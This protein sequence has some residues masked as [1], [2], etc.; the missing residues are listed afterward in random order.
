MSFAIEILSVHLSEIDLNNVCLD[1]KLG[2]L[3][4]YLVW[5]DLLCELSINLSFSG[6]LRR[7]GLRES[8]PSV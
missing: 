5:F 7:F 4:L 2:C 3:Y 6:V 1:C 8:T